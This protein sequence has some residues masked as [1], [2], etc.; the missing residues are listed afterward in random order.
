VTVTQ[1]PS[2]TVAE[3]PA[4]LPEG[5][6]LLD[7]REHHEWAAG[8]APNALHIPMGEIPG[9]LDAIPA[10]AELLVVCKAGGRSAQVVAYLSQAGR[11]AVNVDGGMM[12]WFAAGRALV[13][14]G[15][16]EPYVV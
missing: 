14:D 8:H 9:A 5:V 12:S 4:V 2:T 11:G 3:L 15:V 6:V 1:V 16:V 7:V 10:D 13:S